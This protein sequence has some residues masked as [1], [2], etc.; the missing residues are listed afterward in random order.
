M[1]ETKEAASAGGEGADSGIVTALQDSKNFNVQHPLEHNWVLYFDG[2][3]QYN[4]QHNLRE[5]KD[6]LQ[7]VYTI[8]T[9]EDYWGVFNNITPPREL[10]PGANYYLFKE[11]VPPEWESSENK[12]GGKWQIIAPKS[13]RNTFDLTKMWLNTTM[14]MIG[15]QFNGSDN[16]QICGAVV[17]NRMKGDKLAVWTKQADDADAVKRIGGKFKEATEAQARLPLGYHK[18]METSVP[19]ASINAAPQYSL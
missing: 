8:K 1:A 3:S 16:D 18:H 2:G 7:K 17:Q 12:H 14:L 6:M 4:K 5:W 10:Q 19:G 13:Q 15:Q 11:G 9:V